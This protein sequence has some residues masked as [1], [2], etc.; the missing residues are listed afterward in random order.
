MFDIWGAME[1]KT[2]QIAIMIGCPDKPSAI[3]DGSLQIKAD[4]V[5]EWFIEN[6][7][8]PQRAEKYMQFDG[9]PLL[10]VYLGTPTFISDR[11]PLEVWNDERFTVRYV[12]GYIT[13]QSSLRDSETLESIYGYWSWED[14]GADHCCFLP[15]T[16]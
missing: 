8:Y 13:E 12:T 15:R 2:P 1:E 11:N 6:E 14:R 7:E 10:M 3:E 9:K 16:G 4:Q 5:Y